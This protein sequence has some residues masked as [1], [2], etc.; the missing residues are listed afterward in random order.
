MVEEVADPLQ[1][2]GFTKGV[3]SGVAFELAQE[4][5][6]EDVKRFF[7]VGPEG[8]G[9]EADPGSG[10]HP[11]CS[12]RAKAGA[13]LR[14]LPSV[15]V[16]RQAEG[17]VDGAHIGFPCLGNEPV[18]VLGRGGQGLD[19]PGSIAVRVVRHISLKVGVHGSVFPALIEAAE[20][21]SIVAVAQ[22]HVVG[23]AAIV[24]HVFHLELAA[25]QAGRGAP[26]EA[27]WPAVLDV[28]HGTH[29]VAVLGLKAPRRKTDGLDHVGVG[30][31]EAFLLSGA[32]KEGAIDLNAIDVD[33]VLVEAAALD[34]VGT[35]EFTGEV[36]RGL[37]Q[38]VFDRATNARD[39]GGHTRVD[40]L[41]GAGPGAV[42]LH[43]S[44]VECHTGAKPHVGRLPSGVGVTFRVTGVVADEGGIGWRLHLGLGVAGRSGR[45][46]RLPRQNGCLGGAPSRQAGSAGRIG[47]PSE[48]AVALRH[49][50]SGQRQ[51]Q[52]QEG[53]GAHVR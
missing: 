22:A 49:H 6:A 36:D 35:G 14:D 23:P 2:E 32:H 20:N 27:L 11:V 21:I 25:E 52:A 18:L 10:R 30:E 37:D 3:R 16:D 38:Q 48:D 50:G 7:L 34:I 12:Q 24:R 17:L 40:A 41:N 53:K 4:V 29:A 39:A 42:G 15:E 13:V 44:L 33:E 28:E 19:L 46:H 5:A 1:A 43:F 26:C 45:R 9:D 8:G 51:Q 31:G 47:H